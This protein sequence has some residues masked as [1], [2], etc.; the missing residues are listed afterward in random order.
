MPT[1]GAGK[2][3]GTVATWLLIGMACRCFRRRSA[4]CQE[5]SNGRVWRSHQLCQQAAPAELTPSNLLAAAEGAYSPAS[6]TYRGDIL[7]TWHPS[8]MVPTPVR[9]PTFQHPI[10]KGWGSE[11]VG[12]NRKRLGNRAG[13]LGQ[14]R[15]MPVRT[16]LQREVLGC[17]GLAPSAKEDAWRE[18]RGKVTGSREDGGRMQGRRRELARRRV[19][20]AGS[21][22]NE[23]RCERIAI[24]IATSFTH[25][26]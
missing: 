2:E 21:N 20:R 17:E 18:R 24:A 19:K 25:L 5:V 15:S 12:T 8:S 10:G 22:A 14:T 26:D 23:S 4:L 9:L 6:Q 1:A 7:A 13:P 16:S 3:R 11:P